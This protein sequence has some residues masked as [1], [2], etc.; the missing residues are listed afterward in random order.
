[1]SEWI[2]DSLLFWDENF[3]AGK[4]WCSFLLCGGLEIAAPNSSQIK[5]FVYGSVISE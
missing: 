4:A 3:A 2:G 1:V 5:Y